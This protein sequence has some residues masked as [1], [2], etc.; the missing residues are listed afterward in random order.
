M[1]ADLGPAVA[2]AAPRARCPWCDSHET[3]LAS[4]FGG[5][6]S[7]LLFECLRCRTP[8]GVMKWGTLA[9]TDDSAATTQPGVARD[10]R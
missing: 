4:L 10:C 2:A 1:S 5:T 7:E 9:R 6:V 3:R 8:F